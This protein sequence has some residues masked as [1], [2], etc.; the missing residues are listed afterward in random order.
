[1]INFL[2]LMILP[3]L[4][5][6]VYLVY[7]H[8]QY[9]ADYIE[10]LKD[11]GLQLAAVALATGIGLGIAYWQ[12]TADREIW[13]GEITNKQKLRVNCEHSYPCNP[14]PCNCDKNGCSTCYDTC[15]EHNYDIDW[16]VYSSTN[17]QVNIDRIDRQGLQMPPRWGAAFI[18][19]PFSSQHTF[20]NYI[21]ANPKS[22]LLGQKGD[23]KKWG[24][25]IPEYP[26]VFDYYQ[27][28][29]FLNEGV[30][31]VNE[32]TWNYLLSNANRSL[33]PT[34]QVN[35]IVVAVPTD[36]PTYTYAF[37]DKWLGGKKNDAIILIGSKDGHE[38][39]W[40]DVVSWTPNKE[41]NIYVRDRILEE[42]YLDH[43][44]AI[45]KIISEETTARF[46]RLH[47]KQMEWLMRGFQPSNT[48]MVSIFILGILLSFGAL[49]ASVQM[50]ETY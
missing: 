1:M 32:A 45:V 4:I 34:K 25:W 7:R 6:I 27:V 21:K 36:D 2:L 46:Q 28:N 30:P 3:V 16:R 44:D 38:I 26:E 41:Y 15:Y 9:N 31:R 47:M 49:Y 48:A 43:Q 24:S 42:K 8:S 29:H 22:V 39:N 23:L 5:S 40:V 19:E 37:K 10:L 50:R 33:G 14:H 35:L 12:G 13:N 20:T 11:V 17:E 18:G